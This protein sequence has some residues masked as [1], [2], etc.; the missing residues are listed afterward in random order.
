MMDKAFLD[1][2]QLSWKA[3]GILAYLLS[4]PDNWKAIVGDIIKHAADGKSAV[5]SGLAELKERGYYEKIPVR[6]K[7]GA[8]DHWESTVYELPKATNPGNTPSCPLTGFPDMDNPE[9]D[10]PDMDNPDVDN[11]EMDNPDV[12]NPEM[13]NPEM[14]NPDVDNQPRLNNYFNNNDFNNNQSSQSIP[15]RQDRDRTDL[16][17][18]TLCI[19]ENICYGDLIITRPHDMKLVDEFIAIIIDVIMTKGDTVRIGGEDK[20]RELVKSVLMKLA[21]EDIEHA[22]DQFKGVTERIS[23]KKQYILTTLYNCKLERDAHYK[24]LV[25]SDMYNWHMSGSNNKKETLT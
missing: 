13:D 14:D 7:S 19:K 22:I 1:N 3:K 9:M 2:S 18:Y 25:N 12:D 15:D 20:P 16:N 23:K 4:K 21:Y 8:F 17:G 5:Y 11:P 10:N 24:N 6:N